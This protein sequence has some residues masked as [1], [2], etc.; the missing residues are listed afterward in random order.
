MA[1]NDTQVNLSSYG[2]A[3]NSQCFCTMGQ[4]ASPTP[5][6]RWAAAVAAKVAYHG[7]LDPARPFTNIKLEDILAPVRAKRFT[8]AEKNS[9][10]YDGIS[11]FNTDDNG[12]VYLGRI[13]TMYQ[14]SSAGEDDASYL[15]VPTIL[16]L[17]YIRSDIRSFLQ[18]K[19]PRHKLAD[20]GTKFSSSQPVITPNLIKCE[21]VARCRQWEF[22]GLVENT[23]AFKDSLIV[24]RNALDR[25]RVDILLAPD[26]INMFLVAGIKIQFIL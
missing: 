7:Q 2:T 16:T 24:E 23:E 12:Y 15:D 4:Q 18:A 6:Y 3:L 17:M 20:D 19:Y 21:M 14:R 1:K 13:I 8:L 10:L 25:N 5:N 9:L 22:N 11:T 26:L